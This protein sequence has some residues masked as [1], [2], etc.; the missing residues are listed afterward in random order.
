MIIGTDTITGGADNDYIVGDTAILAALTMGTSIPTTSTSTTLRDL[1][2]LA[3]T[4]TT[5]LTTH[6]TLHH[7]TVRASLATTLAKLPL[8]VNKYQFGNDVVNR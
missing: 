4:R 6:N 8:L 3:T 1:A 2:T 7:K 5:H